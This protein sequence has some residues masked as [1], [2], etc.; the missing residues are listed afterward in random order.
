[1]RRPGPSFAFIP[2]RPNLPPPPTGDIEYTFTVKNTG[3]VDLTNVV[4][5]DSKL[6]ALPL[7]ILAGSLAPNGVFVCS[8]TRHVLQADIDSNAG[9]ALHNLATV[10]ANPPSGAPVTATATADVPVINN[11]GLTITKS[12]DVSSVNATGERP[13]RALTCPAPAACKQCHVAPHIL[14]VSVSIG[15]GIQGPHAPRRTGTPGATR[16]LVRYGSLTRGRHSQL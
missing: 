10:N 3:N 14:L 9:G 16:A 7:C 1:M 4:V 5:T 8:G 13:A 15:I 11:P 6:G 12:A 2:S